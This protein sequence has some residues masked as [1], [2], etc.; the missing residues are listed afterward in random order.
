MVFQERSLDRRESASDLGFLPGS[1][2][3]MSFRGESLKTP[4]YV[5]FSHRSSEEGSPERHI[6]TDAT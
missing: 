4:N 6:N 5:V 3:L 2:T 1:S